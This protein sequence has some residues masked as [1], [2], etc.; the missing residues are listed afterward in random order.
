[1]PIYSMSA[2]V[3]MRGHLQHDYGVDLDK[4]RWVEGA[5]NQPGAHGH[6]S[7]LP[8][9]RSISIERNTGRASR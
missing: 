7:L 6:P 1:M 5:I 3:W 8:L 2:A 4:I 9:V